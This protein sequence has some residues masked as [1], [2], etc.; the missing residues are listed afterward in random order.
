MRAQNLFNMPSY[1][2]NYKIRPISTQY[3]K[4]RKLYINAIFLSVDEKKVFDNLKFMRN[5]AFKIS[6]NEKNNI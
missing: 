6:P 5:F 4:F 3:K 1:I 2:I